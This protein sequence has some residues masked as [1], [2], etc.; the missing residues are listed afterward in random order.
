MAL[1]T[2][3][4][5]NTGMFADVDPLARIC[6][7]LIFDRYCLSLKS[8]EARPGAYSYAVEVD[9]GE[10]LD[11]ASARGVVVTLARAYCVY[12]Q[13]DL[14]RDIGC[15]ER[16][17]RRCVDTL[18]KAQLITYDRD[19]QNGAARYTIPSRVYRYLRPTHPLRQ[20]AR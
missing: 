16:T 5:A 8:N 15:S 3:I 18:R 20:E 14:A 12:S 9:L 13:P 1:Y 4:P 7:G 17:A 19:G 10:E 11:R 6:F 2:L